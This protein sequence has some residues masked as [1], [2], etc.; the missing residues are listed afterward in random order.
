[1]SSM[2]C[3]KPIPKS[4]LSLLARGS[5]SQVP[6]L[7]EGHVSFL[8]DDLVSG[9]PSIC[10]PAFNVHMLFSHMSQSVS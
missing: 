5:V 6:S 9:I 7:G 3:L 8:N 4:K 2:T 10:L 1:M